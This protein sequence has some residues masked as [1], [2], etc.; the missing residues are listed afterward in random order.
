M[1][2]K[3]KNYINGQWVVSKTS[4]FLPVFDPGKG[5]AIAQV[6]LSTKEEVNRAGQAAQKAFKTW[7][8]VPAPERV[9]YLF[10]LKRLIDDHFQEIAR[11]LTTEHG[12]TLKEARGEVKRALQNLETACGIPTLMQ[13]KILASAA[14][15]IDEYF[16]R[17]PVGPAAIIMPFNFPAMISFWYFPYA[18]ACGCTCIIKPSEITPLTQNKIF[19][20]IDEV[21]F[22]EG[23]INLINGAKDTVGAI[24]E[25]KDIK[26]VASV[27]STPVAKVI[28]EACARTHKRACCQAGAKNFLVVAPDA[29]LKKSIPNIINSAFGN[30]GQRCLAGSILVGIDGIYEKLKEEIVRA[31]KKIKVGHGLDRGTYMGPLVRDIARQRVLNYIE[32]GIKEGAELILDGRKIKI[33]KYPG[34]FYLGPSIFDKVTPRMKIAKDEIF[35]PL[36]AII[37]VKNLDEAINLID[38]CPYG[39]A[40]SIY[41]SS[42]R[43]AQEFKHRVKCG[44][45]GIQIGTVAPLAYFSF[46]GMKD[47]FFGTLHGQAPDAIDFFTDKKVIIEKWW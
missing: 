32:T 6:P 16:I 45:I 36:L 23:V 38:R 42:G 13:G 37:K 15:D 44:N 1:A 27:S 22:P 18:L 7:S 8:R 10:K 43:L 4:Q 11:I 30:T 5:K 3:I 21:G 19:E 40:A 29:N 26:A 41:T 28:Y 17:E 47:S 2:K 39:N 34:G 31:A 35:G 46:A 24:L 12:K 25:N 33:K 14:Q 9:E 20:L